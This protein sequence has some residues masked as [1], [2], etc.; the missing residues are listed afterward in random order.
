MQTRNSSEI[1]K[2]I[3]KEAA[4]DDWV[5]GKSLET[6]CDM[7]LIREISYEATTLSMKDDAEDE[8]MFEMEF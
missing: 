2:E 5:V 3:T 7:D 8:I 6:T 4:D 1:T